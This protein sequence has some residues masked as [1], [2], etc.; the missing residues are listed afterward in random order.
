MITD[1][2][3]VVVVKCEKYVQVNI[4]FNKIIFPFGHSL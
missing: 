2:L 3:E 4:F 1:F